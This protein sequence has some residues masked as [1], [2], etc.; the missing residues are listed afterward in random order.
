MTERLAGIHHHLTPPG[1]AVARC[2]R[3]NRAYEQGSG[4]LSHEQQTENYVRE[5]QIAADMPKEGERCVQTG[6]EFMVG[7]GALPRTIQT[8]NF[9]REPEME[10]DI[11]KEGQCCVQTGRPYDSSIGALPKS[12]QTAAFLEQLS[13]EQKA[14]RQ[15]DCDALAA[16]EP[17]ERP[18]HDCTRNFQFVD[19]DR[20]AGEACDRE[21]SRGNEAIRGRREQFGGGV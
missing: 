12:M 7:V 9:F 11:P 20:D 13:P 21:C 17:R 5:A 19:Q 1:Q 6:R 18:D 8:A 15:A 10:A 14:A 3:T 2:P 16:I 4:A